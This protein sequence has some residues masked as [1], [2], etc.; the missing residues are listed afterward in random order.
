MVNVVVAA[1]PMGVTLAGAKAHVAPAGSPEHA[2]LTLPVKPACG[3]TVKAVLA[4]WPATTLSVLVA[5]PSEN[6][7]LAICAHAAPIASSQ[8]WAM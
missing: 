2:K 1:P 4:L 5:A 6:G 8:T 7:A 3:V